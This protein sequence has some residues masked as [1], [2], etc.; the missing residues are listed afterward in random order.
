MIDEVLAQFPVDRHKIAEQVGPVDPGGVDA[1]IAARDGAAQEFVFDLP[2]PD[3]GQ[4][5]VLRGEQGPAAAIAHLERMVAG[6]DDPSRLFCLPPTGRTVG[7]EFRQRGAGHDLR[8]VTGDKI[9]QRKC[10][11]GKVRQDRVMADPGGLDDHTPLVGDD[12]PGDGIGLQI[13]LHMADEVAGRG[14][15]QPPV[16]TERQSRVEFVKIGQHF[17]GAR[18]AVVQVMKERI[19]HHAAAVA[20]IEFIFGIALQDHHRGKAVDLRRQ[21]GRHPLVALPKT[22]QGL[23]ESK[24]GLQV[25]RQECPAQLIIF[26]RY[27]ERGKRHIQPAVAD[28]PAQFGQKGSLT[29]RQIGHG[30]SRRHRILKDIAQEVRLGVFLDQVKHVLGRSFGNGI[31]GKSRRQEFCHR[32]PAGQRMEACAGIGERGQIDRH[33]DHGDK[34]G[35]VAPPIGAGTALMGTV[36]NCRQP[37][38]CETGFIFIIFLRKVGRPGHI[39]C[40]PPRRHARGGRRL[41]IRVGRRTWRQHGHRHQQGRQMQHQ[42]KRNRARPF[43]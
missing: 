3:V 36:G 26:G 31:G 21:A 34:G 9:L 42:G 39:R 35:T 32:R 28:I 17:L 24:G 30:G 14:L 2:R 7:K 15:Q 8:V 27:D 43:S 18:L 4:V 6:A 11:A 33:S 10:L 12:F 41:R 20:R 19:E 29:A 13:N 40:P 38:A 1:R 25:F 37:D 23:I 16:R 22:G 5:V